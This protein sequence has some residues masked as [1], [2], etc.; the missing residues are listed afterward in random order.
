MTL[1]TVRAASR[2]VCVPIQLAHEFTHVAVAAPWAER[3]EIV[4]GPQDADVAMDVFVDFEA[5]APT[6]AV[7]VAHLAP[8]LAGVLGALIGGLVLAV[9]GVGIETGAV[10]LLVWS[11]LAMA[12]VLYT[13]PSSHDLEGARAALEGDDDG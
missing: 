1:A 9:G 8:F 2:A 11:A 7:V 6:W 4:V 12:W 3:W 10:D 5:D 13:R